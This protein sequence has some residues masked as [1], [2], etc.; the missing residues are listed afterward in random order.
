M[1]AELHDGTILEFPDGTDPQVIQ[2]AVKK[3][4]AQTTTPE[5]RSFIEETGRQLGLTARHGIE[6]IGGL[7]DI[8]A[9]PI[10]A[11]LNTVL[12]DDMQIQGQ[13]GKKLSDMIGLPEPESGTQRVVGDIVRAA[14]SG[15]GFVKGAQ[16][17]AKATTGVANAVMQQLAKAPAAQI[18]AAGSSGAASGLTREAGGGAGA[19]LAAGLAGAMAPTAV[20]SA[21]NAG[22]AVKDYIYPSIGSL[23]RRAAGDKADD[24]IAAL[25]KTKSNVPGVKLTAGEASVPA[26][27][28]EFAAFQ[29][30]TSA[31]NASKFY[32]PMGVKGQQATARQEAVRSFGKTPK[33]LASAISNR[34]AASTVNYEKAFMQQ[35][36]ADPSLLKM[37]QNPYV[38]DVLPEALKL[39]QANGITPKANMTEFMHFV[40]LGLDARLQS[41][42]NPNLPALSN[43]TKKAIQDAQAN[44]VSWMG[45]KN[46]LYDAARVSHSTASAPINQMKVGQELEQSLVAPATGAERAASFGNKV[47]NAENTISKSTG[48]PR[49]D[50]L[51]PSQKKVVDAIEEDFLRNQQFKDLALAGKK[52]MEERIGAPTVPPTGMFQPAISAARSWVNKGL[53][54][55]HQQA[56]KRA[57]EVMDNPQ[58]MAR[59]MEAAKPAQRKILEALWAQRLMQGAVT[60]AED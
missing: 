43:A 35:V 51:V 29:K 36:K 44:L 54:S 26:N 23:G 19:Q 37:M 7:Y 13:T 34:T 47:R 48:K 59:L 30:A 58:E 22:R 39:A 31:E 42:N 57:A 18:V 50:S 11:S 27:S 56:L 12:P 38:K 21:I 15:G 8:F 2:A 10:K 20:G 24:V 33:E 9:N 6:G 25:M 1:E 53:G 4:V 40:K 28:A 49:I 45:K 3:M 5:P 17:G 52:G 60:N 46:P 16:L 14:A 55:G 41:A 32:G